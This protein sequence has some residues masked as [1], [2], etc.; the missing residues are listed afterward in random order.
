MLG[1]GVWAQEKLTQCPESRPSPLATSSS[2]KK[3]Q[4]TC[5]QS[6]SS[7]WRL[8]LKLS[9]PLDE[10]L[11]LILPSGRKNETSGFFHDRQCGNRT[12]SKVIP[13]SFLCRVP[14]RIL[15]LFIVLLLKF[16]SFA[17]LPAFFHPTPLCLF[18]TC[19]KSVS[20]RG[21]EQDSVYNPHLIPL[22]LFCCLPLTFPSGL[23]CH[24][25]EAWGER[26]LFSQSKNA[27]YKSIPTGCAFFQDQFWQ[28]RRLAPDLAYSNTFVLSPPATSSLWHSIGYLASAKPSPSLPIQWMVANTFRF[29]QI[30]SGPWFVDSVPFPME[31]GFV[32]AEAPPSFLFPF[33][34]WL[35]MDQLPVYPQTSSPPMRRG[36]CLLPLISSLALESANPETASLHSWPRASW[37]HPHTRAVPAKAVIYCLHAV[38]RVGHWALRPPGWNEPFQNR[39]PPKQLAKVCSLVLKVND[40]CGTRKFSRRIHRN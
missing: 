31:A 39:V 35:V 2:A 12:L 25:K 7:L 11:L 26:Q 10:V 15:Y 4:Y 23:I 5:P 40:G 30:G 17:F 29:M 1:R 33:L 32:E 28:L 37:P 21:L 24:R 27:S 38:G 16:C 19:R 13:K 6:F 36:M 22:S 3:G 8:L 34:C 20:Q 14:P 18:C 9:G